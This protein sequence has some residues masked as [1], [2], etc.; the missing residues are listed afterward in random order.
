LKIKNLKLKIP[1][2]HRGLQIFG[3]SVKDFLRY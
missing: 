3:Q 2:K 1:S